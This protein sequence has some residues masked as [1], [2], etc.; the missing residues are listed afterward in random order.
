MDTKV[1]KSTTFHP[2]TDGQTE[3]V[4]RMIVHILQMYN[5]K[6]P[7]NWDQSLPYIQHSYNRALHSS[8]GHNPFQVCLVFHPLAPIDV[9]LPISSTREDSAHAK[10]ED[11][12]ANHFVERI[13]HIRQQVH[14]ILERANAKY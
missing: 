5:S 2:R 6:H 7:C 4:N 8:I 10:T 3:V 14:E 9:A 1:T 11:D 12:K 13:Q